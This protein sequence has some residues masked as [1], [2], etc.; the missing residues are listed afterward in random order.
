MSSS[1]LL[2]FLISIIWSLAWIARRR[3]LMEDLQ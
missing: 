1:S 3:F 2:S